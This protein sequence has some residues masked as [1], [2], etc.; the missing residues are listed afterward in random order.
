[1]HWT[2]VVAFLESKCKKFIPPNGIELKNSKCQGFVLPSGRQLAVDTTSDAHQANVWIEDC[3]KPQISST[4]RFYN[5]SKTR[6]SALASVAPRLKGP[7]NG[8]PGRRAYMCPVKNIQELE[9][10]FK[11]YSN[12]DGQMQPQIENEVVTTM[13][14]ESNKNSGNR[15]NQILYGPPGTGKTFK[16]AELAV[17]IC[18]GPVDMSRE[19]L[20]TRYEELRKEE[21][22]CFVTFHQSYGY[23]D[24]VEGLRP[25]LKDSQVSYRVRPGIFREACDAARLRTLVKPGLSGIPLN[26]RTIYKMSLGRAGESEGKQVLQACIENGFVL[27]GWGNNI[28]FSECINSDDI[29]KKVAKAL[30]EIENPNPDSQAHLVSMFKDELKAGDIIIV[31]Q[32]NGAFR[33][34]GEVSGDYEFRE[35]PVAGHFHQS[36]AVRWLAVFEGNR[37]VAEIYNKKFMQ[38]SLYKLNNQE[39]KFDVLESLIKGEPGAPTKN[40]VLIIDEINRANI[41]KVFGELITLLE[42]DKRE[43]EINAITVKLPYSGDAFSVPSNLYLIGTMNTAD[44]SIA[45]LDT[46]LRRRFEFEELQPAYEALQKEPVEGVDLRA[47]LKTM[48]ERIEYLY[49]RDHTIGHAYFIDV[50]TLADLDRVFRRKVI[51]LLQEY[52]YENWSKLQS[53]LNDK[54]GGFIEAANSVPAGLESVVDGYD[55][56]PRYSL[57]PTAFLPAAYLR[58]YE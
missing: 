51:P 1:M 55:A 12:L 32:G 43:G 45:L 15:L 53:V 46:A 30:P 38:A 6:T 14:V 41:S 2:K 22:I 56:R 13:P 21:R 47:M 42:P 24:F 52:F 16:T 35:E 40:H 27:L 58:I 4:V 44:R 11:W 33:A 37:D 54:A 57:K 28:D 18:D 7:K 50:K 20:M 23:E 5:E 31:S 34:I 19:E 10:L 9:A 48:N 25:E 36:R 8:K 39:L 3:G 17:E 49:D 29:K 26:K